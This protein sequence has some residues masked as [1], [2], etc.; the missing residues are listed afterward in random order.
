[1][2]SSAGK[3]LLRPKVFLGVSSVTILGGSILY[4]NAKTKKSPLADY[5]NLSPVKTLESVAVKDISTPTRESLLNNLSSTSQFDVLII[6]GGATGTGC[7]VDAVTRGLNVALVEKADFASGTSSK[8]TKMAHGGVRYLE[9]AFLEF[10]K[11][12]LDLVVEALNERA[13]LI[14]TA[15]HLC[16]ILPI[17]IPVYTYWQIPYFYAGCKF[18]D[19]FAGSQNLKSSYLL[20]KANAAELAPMLDSSKL[21]AGLVY[22]DGSFNDSRLNS[23]LAI[24]A[25]SKGATILNYMQV[26]QLIKDDNNNVKGAIVKDTETNKIYEVMAKTVVNATGPYSDHILQMDNNKDG[27]PDID[28]SNYHSDDITSQIAVKNPKMVVPSSGVH[29]ILPSFYCPKNVGLL[30]VR[31]S[32]GRVMFFLPWQGKV[33][34]GTTDIPLKQVPE[35]PTATEAD[36]Q[37]ILKE[38]QHYIKFPVKRDD[39]LSAWAGI[40]PLVKDPRILENEGGKT[41]GLVRSHFIFTSPSNLITI[42]GGKWT[43]YREMAEETIN[44]VVKI[45]NFKDVKPCS[46]RKLKLV[47]AENWN[48]NLEALLAQKYNLSSKMAQHLADSYGTRAPLICESFKQNNIN[49]LPVTLATNFQ[50]LSEKV[51]P[52]NPDEVDTIADVHLI[53]NNEINLFDSFRYPF[54]IGELKYSIQHEYTRTALDFLLRRTRFAF[55][56]ARQALNAVDGTVKIMGD[57]LN[58]DNKRRAKEIENTKRYIKTFGV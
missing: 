3:R 42:A 47:G 53:E 46:T 25:V 51:P 33:L 32:D 45:G 9:K 13:H 58:W 56:D 5:T 21:T 26:Q 49:Q 57:E 12:Q 20:S 48:P 17:L 55:L 41:E 31:T 50:I 35:T 1:M 38:L 39:V 8:S 29:I 34:A 24:T 11:D 44:E 15:P 36:I 54:T 30:D 18:Y 28:S 6:G 43:T 27:L 23:T 22:H 40:R 10:S 16:K 2:F 7:A 19:L 14:N 4:F 52:G 37:D